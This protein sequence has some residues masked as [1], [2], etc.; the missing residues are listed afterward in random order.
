VS[1]KDRPGHRHGFDCDR[2]DCQKSGSWMP[3]LLVMPDL[4][5]YSG[6]PLAVQMDL[7]VCD[8][9]RR[10]TTVESLLTDLVR[11]QIS[12]VLRAFGKHPGI[13]DVELTFEA[14]R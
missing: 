5:D 2:A 14:T 3:T 12:Q 1:E 9:H 13:G 8:E 4:P 6:P 10:D 7:R 11:L